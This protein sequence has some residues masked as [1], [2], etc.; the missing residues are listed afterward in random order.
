MDLQKLTAVKP[1]TRQ[2]EW[3]KLG[4]TAFLH[5]GMNTFT[6]REWGTGKEN[7]G[8]YRPARLDTDQWCEALQSAGIKA[9]V[10]T[11]KHHDGFCLWDTAYTT[12]SVMSSPCPQDVVASLA[13]SCGKYGLKLGL[14]LSPWD[15]HEPSYGS[16]QAYNDFFCGQLEELTTRFGK[17]YSLWFDGACGE[18]PNGKKQIY[19]WDRY[20]AL[21]RRHQ[22]D[23]VIASVGPDVRWIGNEAGGTRASEW[24]VV[25][26]KLQNAHKIAADSQQSDDTRF[27]EQGVKHQDEDLGSRQ[28]LQNET[29]LVWYPAEVDVSIRPGW[30]YHAEED[31]KVK[32]LETLLHFYE[33]SVGG[34]AVLLLNIPPDTDGRIHESDCQRLGA[35]GGRLQAIFSRNL[36][37]EPGTLIRAESADITGLLRDRDEYWKSSAET[38]EIE[39]ALPGPRKLSHLVLQE[40]IRESQRIESF[41]VFSVSA[42]SS[43]PKKIY[44]GT[45]VGFKKICRFDPVETD[46]IR[47]II[48]ASREFS[49]LRFAG[50]YFDDFS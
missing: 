28:A 22:P 14:Y 40:E 21:I 29:D 11:A 8:Q 43:N 6:N 44:A 13:K 15:M 20:Y 34:N 27:R 33:T 37:D 19:D 5:Y 24:S 17:L 42:D 10:F 9:C 46:R 45:T 31:D 23:A 41:S 38:V 32:P 4:F 1:Q 50:A 18:G 2:I 36:L 47:I 3:Q 35:L 16:G 12:H 39:I 25:S 49:T 26:A 30:F 7:P 48:K